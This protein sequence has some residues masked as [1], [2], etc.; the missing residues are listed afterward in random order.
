VIYALAA[1][2]TKQTSNSIIAILL[3]SLLMCSSPCQSISIQRKDKSS[4]DETNL[5]ALSSRM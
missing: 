4:F 1:D 5:V 3:A 2:G